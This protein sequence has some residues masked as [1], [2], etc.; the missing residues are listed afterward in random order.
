MREVPAEFFQEGFDLDQRQLWEQLVQVRA[1][2]LAAA[3][4]LHVSCACP[5]RLAAVNRRCLAPFYNS[6]HEVGSC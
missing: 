5:G 3:S 4:S 2:R 1:A 6:L